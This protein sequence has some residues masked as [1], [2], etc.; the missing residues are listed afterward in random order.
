LRN[1][2]TRA[3]L[4]AGIAASQFTPESE[5][6]GLLKLVN[7]RRDVGYVVV[8]GSAY[9]SEVLLTEEVIRGFYRAN[10]E[11]Y[12][13]V[14]KVDLAYVQISPELLAASIRPTDEKLR[15]HYEQELVNYT[16]AEERDVEYILFRLPRDAADENVAAVYEKANSLKSRILEGESFSAALERFSGGQVEGADAGDTGFFA[17]GVMAPEFENSVF[18]LQT[19]Q[20]SEPIR[21]DF[22][23]QIIRLKAISPGGQKTYE[24]AL[25]EVTASYVAL[26]G[27]K[28]FFEKAEDFSNF[29]YEYPEDFSIVAESMELE[30]KS[31]GL[32]SREA[33]VI[34]FSEE[35]IAAAFDAQVIEQGLNSAPIELPD[36]RLVSFRVVTHEP[37][38]I[39]PYNDV[40]AIV[41]GDLLSERMAEIVSEKGEGLVSRIKAGEDAETLL[42]AEGFDW[43]E[44][45][46]ADRES[47]EVNRT[48]LEAAFGTVL[49]SGVAYT[50]VP[51]GETDFAVVKVSNLVFPEIAEID[52]EERDRFKSRVLS[53]RVTEEWRNYLRGLREKSS[54]TVF[55]ERL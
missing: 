11:R 17:R 12:R 10:E 2:I 24:E 33:L 40:K 38:I 3:Q 44:V 36:G 55:Q 6:D 54:V 19:G 35:A 8:P 48:V 13:V 15:A 29:V 9:V 39:R 42:K 28:L 14:E 31:T 20:V 46:G 26:E 21:T 45:K 53:Q 30:A 37:S 49:S 52:V 47:S 50:G 1:E 5:T 16:V 22:G 25:E 18:G 34:L 32:L 41:Q 7:Q 43:K 4:Y 23:V 51:V 27:Q